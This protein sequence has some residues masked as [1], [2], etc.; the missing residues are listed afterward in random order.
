MKT[1]AY[2]RVS[3]DKQK[4]DQQLNAIKDYIKEKGIS[5]IDEIFEDEGVSGSVPYKERKLYELIQIMKEGD[6]LIV[7]ELSRLGRSM[8][9]VNKL[10]HDE[11]KV[12]KLRLVIVSMGIY[13]DCAKMKAVDEL[14]LINFS[15]SAQVEKE[16]TQ[17][18]TREALEAIKKE[19]ADKGFHVSKKGRICTR[20]GGNGKSTKKASAVSAS[21][22][23]EKARQKPENKAFYEFITDWQAIHGR[24]NAATDWQVISDELNKREKVTSTGLAF[25]KNRARAMFVKVTNIY[26]Y[27]N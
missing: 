26:E 15:F 18:R 24:I 4:F 14:V 21:T 11:L 10:I 8:C 6:L 19:I 7:S 25:N 9:D 1:Y 20:L 17:E 3:T 23:R 2:I 16:M 27:Q 13:L 12:R 22:R 5:K